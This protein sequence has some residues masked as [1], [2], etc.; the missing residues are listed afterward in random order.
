M[1]AYNIKYKDSFR[2]S[3]DI[4]RRPKNYWKSVDNIKIELMPYIKK[5]NGIPNYAFFHKKE[6]RYDIANAIR[7]YGIEKLAR[8][9]GYKVINFN[10]R[11]NNCSVDIGYWKEWDNLVSELNPLIEQYGTIPSASIIRSHRH[12]LEY[13]INLH[14]GFKKVRSKLKLKNLYNNIKTQPNK[15]WGNID[16]IKKELSPLIEKYGT[17]PSASIVVHE[18]GKNVNSAIKRHYGYKKLRNILNLPHYK[19]H[20]ITG[21]SIHRKRALTKFGHKCYI[22]GFTSVVHSHHIDENP[23]NGD[24]KNLIILCPNHHEMLHKNLIK[25]IHIYKKQYVKMRGKEYAN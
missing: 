10:K 19:N 2:L 15:Y 11:Q 14:G 7:S 4:M 16:N 25:D 23:Y 18:L 22:C 9:L 6:K 5:F 12:S 21:Y 17:I 24:I 13:A 1:N 3:G 20:N 8:E